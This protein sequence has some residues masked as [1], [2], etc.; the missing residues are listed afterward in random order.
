MKFSFI[1]LS[2]KKTCMN[3]SDNDQKEKKKNNCHS[4]TNPK[5]LSS[6][7]SPVQ[8]ALTRCKINFIFRQNKKT[9]S[10]N[11]AKQDFQVA[12]AISFIAIGINDPFGAHFCTYICTGICICLTNKRL[13]LMTGIIPLRA[14]RQMSVLPASRTFSSY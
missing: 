12:Y 1:Q 6:C 5:C 2:K 9:I 3:P 14:F 11:K 8:R 4:H 13:C 7:F 10:G